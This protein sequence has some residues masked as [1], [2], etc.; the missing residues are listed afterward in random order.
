MADVLKQIASVLYHDK[1]VN[2]YKFALIR[3]LADVAVGY[4]YGSDND[5]VYIP[6]K[7]LAYKWVAYYWPFMGDGKRPGV[8]QSQQK[9]KAKQ[10]VTF[11]NKLED[12]KAH[13]KCC[14][15]DSDGYSY[16]DEG[17]DKVSV[18]Q[19]KRWS[20]AL[21]KVIDG[22]KMPIKYAKGGQDSGLFHVKK[23]NIVV[24]K[25]IFKALRV[26]SLY[27]EAL[28]VSEWAKWVGKNDLSDMSAGEAF[29]AM[30]KKP[31]G[32]GSIQKY[33]K[34]FKGCELVCPYTRKPLKDIDCDHFE[35]DHVIP[36]AV[37]PIND[38]WNLLPVDAKSNSGAGGK[39]A[40]IPHRD[41]LFDAVPTIANVYELYLDTDYRR[42]FKEQYKLRLGPSSFKDKRS[43]ALKAVNFIDSVA[44][45]RSVGR[46]QPK[47]A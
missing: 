8:L 29:T 19:T 5:N 33:R 43:L 41:I 24:T 2:T 47:G 22:L 15:F 3:S 39:F 20:E 46:W 25:A 37:Y 12:L 26:H 28:A 42:L 34:I 4:E 14:D 21:K 13:H 31:E 11:R 17:N 45:N 6:L 27:I 1:K 9:L 36:V 40:M 7:T 23:G 10:D 35:L 18:E 30:T 44:E 38:L 32:R 16:S